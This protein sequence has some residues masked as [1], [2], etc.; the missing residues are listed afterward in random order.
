[1]QKRWV[2]HV[3]RAVIVNK[4]QF[5]DILA[6]YAIGQISQSEALNLNGDKW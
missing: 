1:M 4:W 5:I 6:K 2:F 3:Q